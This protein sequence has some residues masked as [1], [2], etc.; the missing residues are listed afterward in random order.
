[1]IFED[2]AVMYNILKN[3]SIVLKSNVKLYNYVQRSDS[4]MHSPFS[5]KNFDILKVS[6]VL[7]DRVTTEK[8]NL[9][10]AV[11]SR[12]V[13]A[14]FYLLRVIDKKRY[15]TEYRSVIEVIKKYR[16]T[17]LIDRKSKVK[18]KFGILLSYVSPS[19]ISLIYNF[20]FIKRKIYMK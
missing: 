14:C 3:A 20:S 11:T 4:I 16:W 12:I 19:L 9:K 13:S 15:Q 5:E 10:K 18:I 8:P 6:K 17:V 1:M 2:Y 7:Y